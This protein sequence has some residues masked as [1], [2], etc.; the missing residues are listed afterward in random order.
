MARFL[1]GAPLASF[2]LFV[3]LFLLYVVHSFQSFT[4]L[5]VAVFY[6]PRWLQV[7]EEPAERLRI[8]RLA[9]ASCHGGRAATTAAVYALGFWFR[10]L[11]KLAATV[12]AE[13]PRCQLTTGQPTR[14][15]TYQSTAAAVPSAH[16]LPRSHVAADFAI[17]KPARSE[18][19]GVE[20]S[21][22]LLVFCY[23]TFEVSACALPSR[24]KE[25]TYVGFQRALLHKWGYPLFLSVDGDPAWALVLAHLNGRHDLPPEAPPNPPPLTRV[26]VSAPGCPH[27]NGQAEIGVRNFKNTLLRLGDATP[28]PDL[29]HRAEFVHNQRTT[30]DKTRRP[31]SSFVLTTAPRS[32]AL[33]LLDGAGTRDVVAA[34]TDGT[35]AEDLAASLDSVK[36]TKLHTLKTSARA[37]N[38]KKHQANR[39]AFLKLVR[40]RPA[41]ARHRKSFAL[42]GQVL[43]RSAQVQDRGKWVGPYVITKLGKA[44]CSLRSVGILPGYKRATHLLTS[45]QRDRH[46]KT[47]APN[48]SA[49]RGSASVVFLSFFPRNIWD[50]FAC[51]AI[52]LVFS[53]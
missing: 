27:H 22:L 1:L 7:I 14:Q 25:L 17:M 3:L 20:Y 48:I 8:V 23:L 9:H 4:V 43:R 32:L 2:F 13:C 28:W 41:I 10:G 51:Y 53:F 38:R 47:L 34:P 36:A 6:A 26:R 12:A 42:G 46:A 44:T 18:F 30:T 19:D 5:A 49:N 24:S 31:P 21:A 11:Q 35:P 39:S 37:I 33:A 45:H 52:A 29:V 40:R 15:D 16:Y 50:L